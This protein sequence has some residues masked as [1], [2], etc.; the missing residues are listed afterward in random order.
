MG[1]WTLG[2]RVKREIWLRV[3]VPAA[4]S[5]YDCPIGES[6]PFTAQKAA[7]R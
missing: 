6:R 1:E 7:S 4:D 5:V 3:I 2:G